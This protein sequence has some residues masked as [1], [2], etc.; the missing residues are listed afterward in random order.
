MGV[1]MGVSFFII[2]FRLLVSWLGPSKASRK[3]QLLEHQ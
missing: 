2:E 1:N 3:T